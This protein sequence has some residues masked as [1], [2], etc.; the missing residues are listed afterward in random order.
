MMFLQLRGMTIGTAGFETRRDTQRQKFLFD[1]LLETTK[2]EKR[3]L[4]VEEEEGKNTL[5]QRV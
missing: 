5:Q 3:Q 1:K 2:G 4:K